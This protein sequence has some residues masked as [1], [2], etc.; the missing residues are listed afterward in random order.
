MTSPWA[1]EQ[2]MPCGRGRYRAAPVGILDEY[3][4]RRIAAI[5]LVV[6]AVVGVLAI[7]DVGPFSDPPTPEELAQ[8]T[9]EDFFAAAAAGDFDSFCE[10]M[11]KPARQAIEVR[12][13]AIAAQEGLEGCAEILGTLVGK[14]LRGSQ[15]EITLSSVS[16]NRARVETELKVK[17][18]AGRQQRSVLLELR[19]DEWKIYDPGF[20]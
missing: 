13:G 3:T 6:I 14:Q 10:L 15:L 16:G 9:V 2:P 1:D 20:G 19:R 8:E 17:G 12:A 7:A 5:L 4:R 11:T 18:E